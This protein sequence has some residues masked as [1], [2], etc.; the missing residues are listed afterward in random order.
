M[1]VIQEGSAWQVFL[2][3][4]KTGLGDSE[5]EA[6]YLQCSFNSTRLPAIAAFKNKMSFRSKTSEDIN[7][8]P[9]HLKGQDLIFKLKI[10]S[11]NH[12]NHLRF[13]LLT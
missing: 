3:I 4:C 13:P 10:R 1:E 6:V 9:I 7:N 5:S 8:V 11:L 12:I 2:L